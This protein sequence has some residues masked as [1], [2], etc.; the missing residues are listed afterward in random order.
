M[1]RLYPHIPFYRITQGPK[2]TFF[3]RRQQANSRQFK[4]CSRQMEKCSR[5]KVSVKLFLCSETQAKI[6]GHHRLAGKVFEINVIRNQTSAESYHLLTTLT[7]LH[8][9]LLM[10]REYLNLYLT[11]SWM[12]RVHL[13]I[14]YGKI[15]QHLWTPHRHKYSW[16]K[17]AWGF[18]RPQYVCYGKLRKKHGSGASHCS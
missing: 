6:I 12:F 5:Q 1:C 16:R 8:C 15:S 18:L 17:N 14:N 3:S 2:L 10:P 13:V 11:S 7:D 4:K 9:H